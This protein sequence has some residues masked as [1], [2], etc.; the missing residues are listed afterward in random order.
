[1]GSKKYPRWEEPEFEDWEREEDE[2]EDE[3]YDYR[4][5]RQRL[6]FPFLGVGIGLGFGFGGGFGCRPR[7]GYG[8]GWGGGCRPRLAGGGVAADAVRIMVEDGAVDAVHAIA[9]AD[10][11]LVS[12]IG[13]DINP[14][15]I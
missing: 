12:A 13:L 5:E 1:M 2:D 9:G 6:C 8:Y 11:D 10:A 3:D 14:S 15:L 4:A 7:Y